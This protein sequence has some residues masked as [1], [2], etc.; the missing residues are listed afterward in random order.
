MKC[1]KCKNKMKYQSKE[2]YLAGKKKKCV[3]CGKNFAVNK[4]GW[5]STEVGRIDNRPL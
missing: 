4:A 5:G 2:M 3:Y 1:P